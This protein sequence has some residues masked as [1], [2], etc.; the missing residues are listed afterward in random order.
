MMISKSTHNDTINM[1]FRD[2]LT[3]YLLG[4]GEEMGKGLFFGG[5][6]TLVG[7]AGTFV[8]TTL[9]TGGAKVTSGA[10]SVPPI[11]RGTRGGI[12]LAP[13]CLT[14]DGAANSLGFTAIGF[15]S[16]ADSFAA[17][18]TPLGGTGFAFGVTGTTLGVT[19]VSFGKGGRL[20]GFTTRVVDAAGGSLCVIIDLG[21]TAD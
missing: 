11:G 13:S 8:A 9:A 1:E 10:A 4:S 18:T 2:S 16:G 17:F 21:P 3:R 19:G 14:L 5:S 20:L 6:A 15:G 7:V 12:G